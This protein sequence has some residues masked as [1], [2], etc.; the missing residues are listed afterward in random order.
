MP[1]W[2]TR[3]KT[4]PPTWAGQTSEISPSHELW[5]L[6]ACGPLQ[7]SAVSESY[8]ATWNRKLTFQKL[9]WNAGSFNLGFTV[10]NHFILTMQP[11]YQTDML[12][13]YTT[14]MLLLFLASFNTIQ[15]NAYYSFS[16]AG[17]LIPLKNLP[18]SDKTSKVRWFFS[19]WLKV[20]AKSKGF[21]KNFWFEKKDVLLQGKCFL[22]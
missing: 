16:E 3:H 10:Q 4:S 11:V 18:N 14:I 15:N 5:I 8:E 13:F 7:I 2:A 20:L 21:C 9:P 17:Y 1:L 6:E 12:W 22:P 19:T